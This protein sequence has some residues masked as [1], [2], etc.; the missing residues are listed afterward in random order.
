MIPTSFFLMAG[1]VLM[2]IGCFLVLSRKNL[3]MALMGIELMLNASNLN[4]V[5]FTRNDQADLDGQMA[6]LFIMVLAAAEITV[7][8]A[9]VLAL[10]RKYQSVELDDFDQLKH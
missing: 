2:A 7:A 4:F 8:L 5:A 9:I 3:I 6:G 10:Y 1:A